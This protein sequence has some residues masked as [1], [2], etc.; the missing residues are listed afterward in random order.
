MIYAK[1]GIT[2][3]NYISGLLGDGAIIDEHGNIEAGSLTLREFL[4]VPELRFNRVDVV[5]GELWN[6]IAFGTIESVD[7][8]NQIATLKLE[9]GE[10]SGLHVNDICRGIWHNISG[11]NETTPGTDECGFEKM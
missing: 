10:Y 3:G 11:V 8:K 6:S 1:K 7:T 5:S 4:S 9:E 2:I